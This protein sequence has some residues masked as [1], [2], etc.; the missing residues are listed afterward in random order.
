MH[1]YKKQNEALHQHKKVVYI[2]ENIM[3]TVLFA[4][5]SSR[6]QEITGYSLPAQE[7]LLEEYSQKKNFIVAK[8]FSISESASGHYQRKTFKEML[9]YLKKSGVKIIVCEKVDRLTRNLKDAVCIDEWIKE[10]PERQVHFVKENCILNKDSKSNE[11]FI[12]NIKVSV[13]QY[14]IENLSEEVKKGQKE[15]IAQGWLPTKPPLGY[16]IIGEDGHKI[17]IIDKEK[18]PLVKKMFELYATSNYSI[19]KLVQIMYEEG[20][21]TRDGNKLVKSRMGDLLSDPFYYGKFYWNDEIYDGKQEPLIAKELFDSVQKILKGKTTPKYN[22]HLYL[23]TGLIQ[24][25]ECDGKITWEKQ[26]NIIYG[27][28]NHYRDCSQ[29][30]YVK[31]YEIKNQV[32]DKLENLQINNSRIIEWIR[33]ALKESHKDEMEYHTISLN[34]LNQRYEQLQKRL[35]RLYDDKLDEKIDNDFYN[36]K[37]KQ[38]SEEKENVLQT[39]QKHSQASDKYFELGVNLYE[40]SQKSKE[41]YLKATQEEKRQLIRLVFSKLYINEGN[42]KVEYSKPFEILSEAVRLT[43]SSKVFNL[44]KFPDKIFEPNKIIENKEDNRVFASASP[45]WLA[46]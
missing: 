30:K 43:N 31:E 5:V 8:K 20:L 24:C 34:E 10:D 27:H 26:K 36:K 23:F 7:K 33:K 13:A 9:D 18:A 42:L 4:R 38:Y 15:K 28:C 11:K 1:Y 2:L 35:D 19:K 37:F 3:E 32:L 29:K 22:K 21:R 25:D 40:L 41:I 12:W 6:D 17:H 39:I 44:D 16:E 46:G 14:Y 45:N